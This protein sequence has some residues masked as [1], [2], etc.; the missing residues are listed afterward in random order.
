[1][2]PVFLSVRWK[3]QEMSFSEVAITE[4]F[5]RMPMFLVCIPVIAMVRVEWWMHISLQHSMGKGLLFHNNLFPN[6]YQE[7]NIGSMPMGR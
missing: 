6:R 7:R 2:S 3:D 5:R 4:N 1:M